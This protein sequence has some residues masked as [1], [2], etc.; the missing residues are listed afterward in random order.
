MREFARQFV[1]SIYLGFR[2]YFDF[3]GRSS[4]T[5]F[6]CFMLFFVLAY[7]L[8][9]QLDHWFLSPITDLK[10][11]S[12]GELIPAGYLDNEVGLLV[13]AYRPFM[14]IPTFSVTARRLT[15]AGKSGWWCLLW[16]LPLPLI[17]WFWLIPWLT[18]RSS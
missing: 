14:M 18:R 13:L 7:L 5:E 9:W 6:W 3:R 12:Y 2:H 10:G 17:G 8:I 16:V 15:D 11:L 4:R 1:G